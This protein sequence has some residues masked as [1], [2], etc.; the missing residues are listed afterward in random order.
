MLIF[1]KGFL[2]E[3]PMV[4]KIL[5]IPLALIFF[6]LPQRLSEAQQQVVAAQSIRIAPYEET[7]SAFQKTCDAEIKR[8]VI[9]E[10]RGADL[11]RK[12]RQINPDIVLA[13]GMEALSRV[14]VIRNIPIV[15]LMILNP[16]SILSG[17]KNV[18]GVSM[19]IPPKKQL[20]I[21]R[22]AL[23]DLK[24]FG[25]VYDPAKTGYLV[26]KAQ[27]AAKKVGITLIAKQVRRSMDAPLAIKDMRGKIDAFWILPDLTVITPET[28]E[29]LLLFSLENTIP[30]LAFAEK[31]VEFGALMSIG[32]DS[33]DLGVQGGEMANAILSGKDITDVPR[34]DARKP[35]LSINLKVQRKMGV[36]IDEKIIRKARVIK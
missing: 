26:E 15:Y 8:L 6:I 11:T 20:Y 34:V 33:F 18:T 10:L 21:F 36:R 17:E 29:F 35:V 2:N 30:I 9:S 13:V 28:V 12:I 14:K 27:D 31:Y 19:N 3:T 5:T 24:T 25:L 1:R 7:I 23:P 22:E 32:I 16:H 4:K